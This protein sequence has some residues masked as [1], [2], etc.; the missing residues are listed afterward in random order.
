MEIWKEAKDAEN[1]MVSTYGR[2]KDLKGKRIGFSYDPAGYTR[3]SIKRNGKREW[4]RVHQLVMD[5]FKPQ[6]KED[7]V[8][9]HIDDDKT[10]NALS[11]LRWVTNQEN[12]QKAAN[13]GKMNHGGGKKPIVSVD[14]AG[15]A[16]VWES[17]AEA[18][19]TLGIGDYTIARV[20]KGIQ[21]EARTKDHFYKFFYL[22]LG[23]VA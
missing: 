16:R 9:D 14:E 2:L 13:Q 19:R 11:N 18:S 7:L 5:T 17:S 6:P 21:I 12:L 3:V 8:I 22:D 15:N 1:L 10:N 20:L 23:G 4:R